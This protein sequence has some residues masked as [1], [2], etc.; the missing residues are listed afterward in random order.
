MER[1]RNGTAAQIERATEL[2]A[3]L[4][5]RGLLPSNTLVGAKRSSQQTG[6]LSPG[7]SSTVR[8]EAAAPAARAGGPGTRRS[9]E[10]NDESE[11][12]RN[13]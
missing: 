6:V 2:F 13:R 4:V 9:T 8:K 5:A 12:L 11:E 1:G 3:E 10:H 7:P